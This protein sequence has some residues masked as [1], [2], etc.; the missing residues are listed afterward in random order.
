MKRIF[1]LMLALCMALMSASPVLAEE[2]TTPSDIP[3]TAEPSTEPTIEPADEPTAEPSAEPTD[4]AAVPGEDA[5]DATDVPPTAEPTTVLP[6][7]D[8]GTGPMYVLENGVKHYGTPGELIPL[9]QVLYLYHTDVVEITGMDIDTLSRLTYALDPEVFPAEGYTVILS[10]CDPGGAEKENTVF[11]W[12]SA[13]ASAPGNGGVLNDVPVADDEDVLAW[14]VQVIPADYVPDEPCRP[15]FALVAFPEIEAGMTYAVMLNGGDP[16]ALAGDRFTPDQSGE[17]RFALLDA[18]GSILGKSARYKVTLADVTASPAPAESTATPTAV[19]AVPV[20]STNEPDAAPTATVTA[21]PT[22]APTAAPDSPAA[23]T[24]VPAAPMDDLIADMDRFL[25]ANASTGENGAVAW[26]MVDG[27]QVSGS[28]DALLGMACDRIYIATRKTIVLRCDAT[29]L[30]GKT[31]LPD[32]DVFGS[33]YTVILADSNSSVEQA[34]S[35]FVSVQRRSHAEQTDA[36]LTVSVEGSASGLWTAQCPVFRLTSAPD[37]PGTVGGYSYAVSVDGGAPLRLSGSTY[38]A[39]TEGEYALQFA[40]VD[41]D[42]VVVAQGDVYSVKLDATAPLLSVS[43]GRDGTLMIVA[44]D[45]GSG[46]VSCSV[47]G[48]ATWQMMTDQG[49]GVASCTITL[50]TETT[51]EPGMIIVQDRAGNRT[52]WDERVTVAV[53]AGG[54][55][56]GMGSFGGSRGGTSRTTSH[57]ASTQTAV[58]VY[59]GVALTVNDGSMTQLTMGGEALDLYLTRDDVPEDAEQPGFTAELAVFDGSVSTQADTLVL[60]AIGVTE[61]NADDYAWQFS[62]QVYKKLAASGI[63]YLVLRCGERVTAL[64]TAG[65]T[66]GVRYSMF[67]AEGLPSKDFIYTL[68]MMPEKDIQLAMTVADT[69]WCLTD[70]PN[71]EIYYYDVTTDSAD[72]FDMLK[73]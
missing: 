45:L 70:D 57:A 19:P 11:L 15:S 27:E 17:Y 60:T 63:D 5:A 39:V 36:A 50:E 46:A 55:T 24:A 40:I 2:V 58:T 22:V 53:Q 52:V 14:E 43:A 54:T 56:S 33:D 29:A 10:L 25:E 16:V 7:G 35:L 71:A 67:R 38:A 12:V 59:N 26:A 4:D 41:P 68:R 47:D 64:S 49:D 31:L 32:P 6:E 3:A 34:G 42:S 1:S 30:A 28:L 44:G 23:P 37:L 8:W 9:G 18:Q 51:Y 20:E 69:T 13:K 65:F 66:A 72:A 21:E 73:G 48:G 61:E 62:G